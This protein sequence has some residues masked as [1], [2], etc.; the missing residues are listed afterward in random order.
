LRWTEAGRRRDTTAKSRAEALAKAGELVERLSVGT[1]HRSVRP[2]AP[3]SL[4]AI[5]IRA[6]G[7]LGGG[8]GRTGIGRSRSRIAGG[9]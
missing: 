3:H 6:G 1:P 8:R 5:W 7:R 4:T 9:S 2:E